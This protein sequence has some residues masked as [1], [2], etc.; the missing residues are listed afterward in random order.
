MQPVSVAL[1]STEVNASWPQSLVEHLDADSFPIGSAMAAG[2]VGAGWR[3][4]VAA[5]W[6]ALGAVGLWDRQ[7]GCLAMLLVPLRCPPRQPLAPGAHSLQVSRL[8]VLVVLRSA[9][10]PPTALPACPGVCCPMAMMPIRERPPG[11]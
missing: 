4:G 7:N 2:V 9:W 10:G 1:I 8:L 6:A 5:W 3:R 11:C